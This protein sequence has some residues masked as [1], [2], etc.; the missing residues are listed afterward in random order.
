[1]QNRVFLWL[2]SFIFNICVCVGHRM[3][4]PQSV[5]IH[6]AYI[7]WF[8]M[9]WHITVHHSNK[10]TYKNIFNINVCVLQCRADHTAD[11]TL[12]WQPFSYV[13]NTSFDIFSL[14]IMRPL[15]CLLWR[16]IVLLGPTCKL[17]QTIRMKRNWQHGK[18]NGARKREREEQAFLFKLLTKWKLYLKFFVAL[19]LGRTLDCSARRERKNRYQEGVIIKVG[20]FY[21]IDWGWNEEK[22][23][24]ITEHLAEMKVNPFVHELSSNTWVPR[25]NFV[26]I[27][28]SYFSVF[29]LFSLENFH[30]IFV[31]IKITLE[32]YKHLDMLNIQ[33]TIWKQMKK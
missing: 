22:S 4:C 20:L 23:I 30:F 28:A 1:M 33:K 25:R 27:P 9:F 18:K 7:K 12:E 8:T 19:F 15:L 13:Q 31:T 14:S 6:F 29:L 11:G 17:F 2:S 32:M 16:V 5:H 3:R 24:R 10:T 21:I 26:W